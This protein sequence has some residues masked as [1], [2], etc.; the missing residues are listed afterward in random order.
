M[1]HIGIIW[2]KIYL[3]TDNVFVLVQWMQK[4]NGG[5]KLWFDFKVYNFY[6]SDG[7]TWPE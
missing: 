5:K 6:A 7:K 2:I 4:D 1:I 3:N